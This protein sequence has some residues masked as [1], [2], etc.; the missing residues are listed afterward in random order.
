MPFV[1]EPRE[2]VHDAL[3]PDEFDQAWN[4]G[5]SMSLEDAVRLALADQAYRDT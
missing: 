4:Q 1:S 3:A 2:A 5:R